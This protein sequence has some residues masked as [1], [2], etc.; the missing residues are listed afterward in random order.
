LSGFYLIL[1]SYLF[2]KNSNQIQNPK[3]FIY[4]LL[5]LSL[6]YLVKISCQ[7]RIRAFLVCYF[8]DIGYI[9]NKV[10]HT[11]REYEGRISSCLGE[12][13]SAVADP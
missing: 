2:C 12:N 11:A 8:Q 5:L 1:L 9:E 7:G 3:K 13:R 6:L 4:L 10:Q